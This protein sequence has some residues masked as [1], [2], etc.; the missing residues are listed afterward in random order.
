MS[1]SSWLTV[2]AS[3]ALAGSSTLAFGQARYSVPCQ[4]NSDMHCAPHTDSMQGAAISGGVRGG[5]SASGTPGAGA[6]SGAAAGASSA[7]RGA[8]GVG[9][10]GLGASS[11]I[12]PAGS[13]G[14]P[15]TGGSTGT[16]APAVWAE[17]SAASVLALEPVSAAA[18]AERD[19]AAVSEVAQAVSGVPERARAPARAERAEAA[20][21][22]G[23]AP[24]SARA[25]EAV[26]AARDRA[27]VSEVD[28]LALPAA[29]A[30]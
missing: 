12:G 20:D 13:L 5:P 9:A 3:I 26:R 30:G 24:A 11:G 14:G 2:G 27:A 4:M 29:L 17:G 10:A 18:Q 28:R 8:S 22:E 23:L 6:R 7:G 1:K 25:W 19:R 15:G 21:R 16:G